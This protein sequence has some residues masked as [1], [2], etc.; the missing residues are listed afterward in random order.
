LDILKLVIAQ[1]VQWIAS[2]VLRFELALNPDAIK[3]ADALALLNLAAD[4][5][6]LT[7]ATRQHARVLE[8]QGFSAFDALH[9]AVCEQINVDCMI[10]V[11]DRLLRKAARLPTP[12]H[13]LVLNPI[14]WLRRRP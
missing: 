14:E 12:A 9:F 2:T 8:S 6:E 5:V 11:D 1:D 13:V 10:T 7:P 3:R 4:V